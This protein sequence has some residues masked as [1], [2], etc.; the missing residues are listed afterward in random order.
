MR[1]RAA[2]FVVL[3]AA[4]CAALDAPREPVR[5][6]VLFPD[7]PEARTP[8]L[9]AL[10]R[11][12]TTLGYR[13]GRNIELDVRYAHSEPRR[14]RDHAAALAA[15][16]S[17]LVAAGTGPTDALR[18]AGATQP[19]LFVGVGDPVGRGYV[20]DLDNPD[21]N[22]TGSADA[23]PDVAARRIALIAE[24]LPAARRVAVI[25]NASITPRE[26]LDRAAA[27]SGVELI[28]LDVRSAADFRVVYPALARE[29]PHALIVV[30][31][32]TTFAERKR[33][34][35]FCRAHRI[36]TLFGWRAFMDAGG[37]MSLGANME[38]LYEGA[39]SQLDRLLKGVPPAAIPVALPQFE[40]VVDL[41]TARAL[42]IELPR[43]VIE[44]ADRVIE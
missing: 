14:L 19:I 7:T 5:V 1:P 27:A 24:A 21:R 44:R 43:T 32:P 39:A 20:S 17:V 18:A 28:H 11:G 38:R 34:A 4:G 26:P 33:L 40:L 29:T 6:G 35:A 2:T 41:R 15:T 36:A 37:L 12:L 16:T 10:E 3:V 23:V 25:S 42:G 30:P 8:Q 31:N 22:M 9:A 13:K